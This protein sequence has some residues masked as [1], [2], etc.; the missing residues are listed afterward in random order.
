[1]SA[2]AALGLLM[3]VVSLARAQATM[4]RRMDLGGGL[5][6][7]R[8]CWRGRDSSTCRA[9]TPTG[10]VF[11]NAARAL[12]DARTFVR[13]P[14]SGRLIAL[15]GPVTGWPPRLLASG[16]GGAHWNDL[17]WEGGPLPSAFAFDNHSADGVAVGDAGHVW[18]TRD[19]GA[20]WIDHGGDAR[21]WTSVA[22]A[23][24]AIVLVDSSGNTFRSS[25][26]GFTRERLPTEGATT[27][28]Q[29]DDE[30]LVHAYTS[31]CV[32]RRGDGV[33]CTARE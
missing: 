26:G 12:E 28:E 5:A 8:Q 23:H 19:G 33:H 32:V 13:V 29:R 4:A 24:G 18:S 7:E 27:L 2:T 22:I 15:S 31:D 1:M 14:S 10:F 6:V 11:G 30:I 17:H 21:V 16:D 20:H 3:A 9:W 25:D